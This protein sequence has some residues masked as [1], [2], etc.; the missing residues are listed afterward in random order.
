ME[1]RDHEGLRLMSF[2]LVG[3]LWAAGDEIDPRGAGTAGELAVQLLHT[4]AWGELDYLV[5]D[6]PPGTGEVPRALAARGHLAGAVGRQR[7]TQ[8]HI[9]RQHR[10]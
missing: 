1:P 7:G 10:Y 9:S 5:I 2:G 6:T 8:R 4:T 3:Q